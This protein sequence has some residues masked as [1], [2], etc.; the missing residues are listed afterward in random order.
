M[1]KNLRL[2][3]RGLEAD[4]EMGCDRWGS[5]TWCH[6]VLPLDAVESEFAAL[7]AK[8]SQV[9]ADLV[10]DEAVEKRV[11]EQVMA[12]RK[13]VIAEERV[14]LERENPLATEMRYLTRERDEALADVRR[15]VVRIEQLRRELD[16]VLLNNQNEG[17]ERKA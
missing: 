4:V 8:F 14:R 1:I 6:V 5:K 16:Q 3:R 9:A 11:R 13:K 12:L 17:Q 15:H 10:V 2:L 7:S